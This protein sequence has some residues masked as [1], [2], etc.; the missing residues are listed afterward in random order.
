M[1][2]RLYINWQYQV[3]DKYNYISL[4]MIYMKKLLDS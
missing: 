1:I 4:L 2:T 3:L